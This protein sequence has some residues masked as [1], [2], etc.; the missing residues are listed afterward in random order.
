MHFT[1]R[2]F[3]AH[4]RQYPRS[5]NRSFARNRYVGVFGDACPSREEICLKSGYSVPN[6]ISADTCMRIKVIKCLIDTINGTSH[7]RMALPPIGGCIIISMIIENNLSPIKMVMRLS[8]P[9]VPSCRS[10]SQGT[11]VGIPI[12]RQMHFIVN[13]Y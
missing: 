1:I 3:F 6:R 8:L 10:T 13:G 2:F 11:H 9:Q 7:I 12:I 4:P 5:I